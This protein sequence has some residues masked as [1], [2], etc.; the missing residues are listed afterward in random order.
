MQN[1]GKRDGKANQY[2]YPNLTQSK[3][4]NP[5]KSNNNKRAQKGQKSRLKPQSK[6][7]SF[8][9]FTNL[10]QEPCDSL[11]LR[12]PGT[13]KMLTHGQSQLILAHPVLANDAM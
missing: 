12:Q 1:P 4:A 13:I 8:P 9:F 3:N 6:L 5:S 10:I 2:V 11:L 7:P